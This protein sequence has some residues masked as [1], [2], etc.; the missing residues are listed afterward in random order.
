M[1]KAPVT[2]RERL[3][4]QVRA[5]LPDSNLS[6]LHT[7]GITDVALCYICSDELAVSRE[8]LIAKEEEI[9]KSKGTYSNATVNVLSII[10]LWRYYCYK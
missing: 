5:I 3:D 7:Y 6:L 8:R 10:I 4:H 2:L 1:S 9:S